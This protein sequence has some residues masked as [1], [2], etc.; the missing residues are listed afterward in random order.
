MGEHSRIP[1]YYEFAT[2]RGHKPAIA[3]ISGRDTCRGVN[4]NM[5][6]MAIQGL[7]M[8]KATLTAMRQAMTAGVPK[9]DP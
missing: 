1:S 5:L 4:L 3:M 6:R 8:E 2:D 9:K 7:E